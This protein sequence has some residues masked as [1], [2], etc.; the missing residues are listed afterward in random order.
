MIELNINNQSLGSG[1]SALFKL[2]ASL[3]NLTD[4]KYHEQSGNITSRRIKEMTDILMTLPKLTGISLN[5]AMNEIDDFGVSFFLKQ[6]L[7]IQNLTALSLNLNSCTEIQE[8]TVKYL[9]ALLDKQKSL[10]KLQ[11]D[12]SE[13][14]ITNDDLIGLWTKIRGLKNLKT[15]KFIHPS[16]ESWTNKN[17]I[18]LAN[19]LSELPMLSYLKLNFAMCP[20]IESRAFTEITNL[21]RA[22]PNMTKLKLDYSNTGVKDSDVLNLA[23]ALSQLTCLTTVCIDPGYSDVSDESVVPLVEA[24]FGLTKL[25]KLFLGLGTHHITDRSIVKVCDL[26]RNRETLIS[27]NLDLYSSGITEERKENVMSTLSLRKFKRFRI[28]GKEFGDNSE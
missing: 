27:L 24:L 18:R 16:D 21:I 17:C 28:D 9:G 12:L 25:T 10:E 23:A 7:S 6:L 20:F 19:A 8:S 4:F 2:I 26:V 15:F 14:G 11:L 22:R 5:L 3:K 13:T 1:R